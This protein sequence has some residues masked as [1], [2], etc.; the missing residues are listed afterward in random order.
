MG[1]VN[2][3]LIPF[4]RIHTVFHD[5]HVHFYIL[6]NNA[7]ILNPLASHQNLFSV[8]LIVAIL[9]GMKGYLM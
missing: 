5:R 3:M 1:L 6:I 9:M 4:L 2:C 7:S 8:L